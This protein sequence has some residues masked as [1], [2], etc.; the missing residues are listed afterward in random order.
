MSNE[1]INIIRKAAMGRPDKYNILTFPTHER[2]QTQMCKTGHDFYSF[3]SEGQ[4]E[5]DENYA[6]KPD[7][8]YTLPPNAIYEGI[9]YDFILA[10]S[11]FGQFQIA[12]QINERL[13]IPLVSLEHTVPIPSWPAGQEDNMR[14]MCG[15]FNV[16]ISE[17]SRDQWNLDESANTDVIHHGIDTSLFS[18]KNI[19]V[20]HPHVLTVANDFIKRDYCLNYSGWTRITQGFPAMLLGDTE[21]LSQPA[22][23]VEALVDEYNLAQVFLNTSTLSPVPTSLL[24]AMSCGCAV[25]STATCMIPEVITN[26]ENG[27]ISNDEEE[28]RSY[29]DRLLKD[30]V[31]ATKLGKAARKT[32]CK[33]FS[34]AEFINNWNKKFDE[35]MK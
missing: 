12:G 10:Q 26:G 17:H 16:F 6:P 33:K 3:C 27:F 35:V 29:I 24:E 1:V 19:V 32:I 2:Y 28:L 9:R 21:G 18:D 25:V 20:K 11:K 5:W 7:N 14:S 23:S 15:D 34:E 4:K 13:N 22:P 8:Y 30:K 31:L